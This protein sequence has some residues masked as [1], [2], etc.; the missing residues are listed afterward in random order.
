[1]RVSSF[2]FSYLFSLEFLWDL[3]GSISFPREKYSN[4]VDTPWLS[5]SC[6]WSIG[7]FPHIKRGPLGEF[8]LFTLE[9][10][11]IGQVVLGLPIVVALTASA[12]ESLEMQHVRLSYPWNNEKQLVL[13][14]CGRLDMPL[15]CYYCLQRIISEVGVS[16]M[17]GGN[18]K[19][20]TRSIT[21]A[22]P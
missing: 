1:M 5:Y 2:L 15:R 4:P 16:M 8:G 3:L 7:L 17:L 14:T 18:I 22:G 9:G 21:T 6:C 20:H 12:T 10:I 19:W 13:S 11:V